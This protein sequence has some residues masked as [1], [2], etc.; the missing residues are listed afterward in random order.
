MN[1]VNCFRKLYDFIKKDIFFNEGQCGAKCKFMDKVFMYCNLFDATILV[2]PVD[3]SSERCK[4]C[5]EIFGKM[6]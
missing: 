5:I 4:E 1:K 2:N 6:K 3:S